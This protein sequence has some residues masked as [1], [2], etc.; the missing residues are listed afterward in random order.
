MV[1][2]GMITFQVVMALLTRQVPDTEQVG[3]HEQRHEGSRHQIAGGGEDR[4]AVHG[5]GEAVPVVGGV[6]DGRLD[7]DGCGTGRLQP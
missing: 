7:L 6:G 5:V 3:H 1:K 4:G 2:V